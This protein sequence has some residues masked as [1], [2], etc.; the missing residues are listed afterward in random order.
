MIGKNIIYYI[1]D[2]NINTMWWLGYWLVQVYINNG[3]MGLIISIHVTIDYFKCYI[4]INGLINEIYYGFVV[5][6]IHSYSTSVIYILLYVHIVR[7]ILYCTYYY[8]YWLWINGLYLVIVSYGISYCGYVL[9]CCVLSIWGL[10]VISNVINICWCIN[11]II[12][13]NNISNV[14]NNCTVKRFYIYH[15]VLYLIILVL[16]FIHIIYLHGIGSNN[17]LGVYVNNYI[18]MYPSILIN[19]VMGYNNICMLIWWL[20]ISCYVFSNWYNNILVM[21]L[22]VTPLHISPEW[23][24]LHLYMILKVVPSKIDG[25]YYMIICIMVM[26]LFS[27]NRLLNSCCRI[28]SYICSYSYMLVCYV[29]M[30]IGMCLYMGIGL[31]NNIYISYGRCVMFSIII[32]G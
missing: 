7:N 25:L 8:N 16:I 13:C 21:E 4:S 10:I 15:V 29:L 32:Y 2:V 27:E 22:L 6:N 9:P 5:I 28:I 23:Y 26:I 17:V 3:I 14:N 19:D 30:F 18:Y 31:I 1:V 11:Y 20:I 24:L 12:G